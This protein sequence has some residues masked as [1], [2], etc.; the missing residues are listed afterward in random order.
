[1]SMAV[2]KKNI[3]MMLPSQLMLKFKQ[4]REQGL[5]S[6]TIRLD[7]GMDCDQKKWIFG[8]YTYVRQIDTDDG[9]TWE[10][11]PP[12]DDDEVTQRPVVI[13]F[14]VRVVPNGRHN[15]K[16]QQEE[17]EALAMKMRP[18]DRERQRQGDFYTQRAGILVPSSE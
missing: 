14:L 15:T 11:C 13:I 1:M 4:A 17:E 5:V 8:L 12:L 10:S 16:V 3:M 6:Q 7:Q 9:G 2:Q 18:G